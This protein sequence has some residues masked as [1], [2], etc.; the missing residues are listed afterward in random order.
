[1]TATIH[2]PDTRRWQRVWALTLAVLLL[3]GCG[4]AYAAGWSEIDAGYNLLGGNPVSA[5][6]LAD[7]S[8]FAPLSAQQ[9]EAYGLDLQDDWGRERVLTAQVLGAPRGSVQWSA[10]SLLTGCTVY[11][12][13]GYEAD[14][15]VCVI[16][17]PDYGYIAYARQN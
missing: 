5:V 8:S 3:I 17:S 12:L 2:L 14:E 13:A 4:Y 6:Q 9:G 11:A 16:A 10:D 15:D 1:M 7:G